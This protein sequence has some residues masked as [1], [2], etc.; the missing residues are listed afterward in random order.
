VTILLGLIGLVAV[1]GADSGAAH[2]RLRAVPQPVS[3]ARAGAAPATGPSTSP[4]PGTLLFSE[5][6]LAAHPQPPI[7][8]KGVSAILV[9]LDTQQVL[10][11][12][13]PHSVRAPA[14]LTKLVTA[15]VVA[16][17][18]RSLDQPVT[19]PPE[20]DVKAIQQIEPASTVMGI[21]AGE[22]LTVRELLTGLFLRSGND[23]AEALA[24][25]IGTRR[26]RFIELMNEKAL[27]IG[28]DDSHFT[29]PIGL[30][31]PNMKSAA[32]D[33]AVAAYTIDTRYPELAVIADQPEMHLP[34]TPTHKQ[35]DGVNWLHS[36][37]KNY[38]GATGMKTGYTDDAGGC[39]VTT[40]TRGNRHL[41]AVVMHS[42]VMVTD[43][44]HLLD[45]G[46]SVQPTAASAGVHRRRPTVP[47]GATR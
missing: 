38:V 9:D 39:S 17:R 46:F 41:I 2:L 42:G 47:L 36:F 4:R 31:D 32:Y 19:V 44:E 33:L 7:D 29:T 27:E 35:F 37:F 1:A 30:D 15:M 26:D 11:E 43:A 20:A 16:D 24:R 21:N 45:Y 8:V 5:S 34:A 3:A 13:D 18:V 23:A 14:S 28:M 10:W 22:V 40:A 6:W 25:G 12:R